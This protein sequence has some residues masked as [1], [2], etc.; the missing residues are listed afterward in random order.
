MSTIEPDLLYVVETSVYMIPD[1]INSFNFMN[2]VESLIALM[3]S[4]NR[5]S[6][7]VYIWHFHNLLL[8]AMQQSVLKPGQRWVYGRI[9]LISRTNAKNRRQMWR[10]E[11][12]H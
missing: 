9:Y 3:P 1:N 4:G 5:R 8:F 11:D 7:C 6:V 12:K 2:S 10:S